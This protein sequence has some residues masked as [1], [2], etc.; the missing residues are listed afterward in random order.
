MLT[1]VTNA[2]TEDEIYCC[3]M[4]IGQLNNTKPPHQNVF[5]YFFCTLIMECN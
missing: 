3:L 2:D 4:V 1:E 5:N